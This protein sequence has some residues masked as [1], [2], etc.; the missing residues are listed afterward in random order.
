M[1]CWRQEGQA[2]PFWEKR[3]LGISRLKDQTVKVWPPLE[4]SHHEKS[5]LQKPK[6][7]AG[8]YELG[9]ILGQRKAFSTIAGRCSAAEAAT[10]RRV[11]EERLYLSTKLSWKQFCPQY[12]GMSRSQADL[13]IRLLEEF[14]PD[15]FEITQ[16]TKVPVETYRAIAPAVKDGHIHWQGTS[17]ALI[18]ENSERVAEAVNGLRAEARPEETAV[19]E[20][21]ANARTE[22]MDALTGRAG[23]LVADWSRLV[24]QRCTFPPAERQRLKNSIG[25]TR[26][27][28]E[29][30]ERQ[31]WR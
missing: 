10:L 22:A 2:W 7:A 12:L 13:T 15:F 25:K 11:R 29:R 9:N 8:A 27:E 1:P 19:V 18:P 26:V 21:P 5:K 20:P 17:I 30:L 3:A 4:K 23:Q 31:V 28:L 6:E 16:L 14:G 24:A